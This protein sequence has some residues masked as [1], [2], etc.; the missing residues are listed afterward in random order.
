M[1]SFRTSGSVFVWLLFVILMTA[2]DRGREPTGPGSGEVIWGLLGD[3]QTDEYGGSQG[4]GNGTQWAATTLNWMEQLAK[5]RGDARVPKH[6]RGLDF[7]AWGAWGEPRRTG[8]RYNWARSSG[9]MVEEDGS[10]ASLVDDLLPG[11][12]QQVR[13]GEVTHG[14]IVVTSNE[15]MNFGPRWAHRIYA[16]TATTAEGGTPHTEIVGYL[17][18]AVQTSI[19]TLIEAGI[20]G[21][22]AVGIADFADNPMAAPLL[23][24]TNATRR[25]YL[26]AVIADYNSRIDDA[27][28]AANVVRGRMICTF[29]TIS[30]GLPG[31]FES[32]D[33]GIVL[34]GG[35][36]FDVLD[37]SGFDPTRFTI[38]GHMGTVGN[39]I[40]ANTIIAAMNRLPGISIQ[41]F[42]WTEIFANAGL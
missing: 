19:D 14:V 37:Q 16:G 8:Y 30:A 3:S 28:E 21:L 26:S 2:C 32:Y 12:A 5:P 36:P 39:G 6:N 22:V 33:N 38:P 34:I 29:T 24:W 27:C 1:A 41:P 10:A 25:G 42:T 35:R 18:A 4:R 11:L 9:T 23:G 7:G 13:N 20:E 17:T 40:Y 15:W 31:I